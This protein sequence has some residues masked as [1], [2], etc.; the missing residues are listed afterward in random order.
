MVL[1]VYQE[2]EDDQHRIVSWWTEMKQ[3]SVEGVLQQ[4][5]QQDATEKQQTD[6]PLRD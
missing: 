1:T 3:P 2:M 6:M 5:P 4:R